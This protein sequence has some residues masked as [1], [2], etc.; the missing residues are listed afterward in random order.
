MKKGRTFPI[1][2]IMLVFIVTL[3]TSCSYH[4][5]EGFTE[6]HHTYE[7]IVA[8]AKELDENAEVFEEYQ[9]TVEIAGTIEYCYREWPAVINGIECHVRRV[10]WL[11]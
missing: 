2:C 8:F 10:S 6:E 7:E 3:L 11:K 4:P 1:L 9:D 5:P